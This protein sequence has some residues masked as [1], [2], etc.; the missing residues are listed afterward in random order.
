MKAQESGKKVFLALMFDEMAIRKQVIWNDNL[1]KFIGYVDFGTGASDNDYTEEATDALVFLANT[2]NESWKLPLAYYFTNKFTGA[3]KANVLK[4]LLFDIHETGAEVL[5]LTF[6]GA[7]NNFSLATEMGVD[8]S[9]PNID[10]NF[11]FKNPASGKHVHIILDIC[12]M[13]LFETFWA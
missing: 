12:H 9:N 2:V 6:D 13:I 10:K 5:S 3:E 7:Q 1:K 8:F 11:C 4:Q